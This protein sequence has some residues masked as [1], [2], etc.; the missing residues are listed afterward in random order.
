MDASAPQIN[1]DHAL[2]GL[3]AAFAQHRNLPGIQIKNDAVRVSIT[4]GSRMCANPALP[5]AENSGGLSG[6]S[7]ILAACLIETGSGRYGG[8]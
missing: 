1:L 7:E 4:P 6:E 8:A 3:H 2:I 5:L